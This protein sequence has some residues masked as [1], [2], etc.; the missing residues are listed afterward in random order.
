MPSRKMT[1]LTASVLALC[2]ALLLPEAGPAA[3]RTN[4]ELAPRHVDALLAEH[5]GL[6][7]IPAETLEQLR[8]LYRDHRH[9]TEEQREELGAARD[10]LHALLGLESP[11]EQAVL[12]QA[13]VVGGL[14]T[15]IRKSSLSLRLSMRAL[16]T[17][18]QVEAVTQALE[19]RGE[20]GERRHRGWERRQHSRE[21]RRERRERRQR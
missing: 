10:Q 9:A 3:Q 11:D 5:V 15:A 20:R 7:D 17:P 21:E 4:E 18:E 6:L 14:Q 13:D 8:E 16:L 2:L 1:S 12:A 19:R